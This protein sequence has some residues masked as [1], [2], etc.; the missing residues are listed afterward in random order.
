MRRMTIRQSRCWRVGI[1][2]D[3]GNLESPSS[4]RESGHQLLAPGHRGHVEINARPGLLNVI[5]LAICVEYDFQMLAPNS[6]FFLSNKKTEGQQFT[7]SLASRCFRRTSCHPLPSHPHGENN[8]GYGRCL[9]PP[10]M[11]LCLFKNRVG[12]GAYGMCVMCETEPQLK[13]WLRVGAGEEIAI[14]HMRFGTLITCGHI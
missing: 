13:T 2:G 14:N 4:S 11:I 12:R 1:T 6:F 10:Q 9:L 7:I 3:S 8:P 5:F